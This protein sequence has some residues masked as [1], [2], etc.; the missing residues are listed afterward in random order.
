MIKFTKVRKMLMGLMVVG[1][2][3][4]VPAVANAAPSKE[5]VE[6]KKYD[7]LK[8]AAEDYAKVLQEISNYG[9]RQMLKSINSDVDKYVAKKNNATL[10]KQWEDS[11]T[12]LIEQ[13]DVSVYK[14]NENG[15]E[16]EVVFLI[17]GYDE[18]ALNKYLGDNAS[19]Y[20]E[21]VDNSKDEIEVNIDKYIKLQY[22]YLTKTKKIN[23]ATSTVKFKK[24]S[25]NKW[26]VVK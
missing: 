17:K 13:F 10:K 19:K 1:Q 24:G 2:L 4:A 6:V 5:S 20:V 9:S 7:S 14:V 8:A 18:N 16:G 22:D 23:L 12:M 11:N 26:Q 21:K 15:N 25:D 3:I